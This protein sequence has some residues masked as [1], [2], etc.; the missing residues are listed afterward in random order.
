MICKRNKRNED[1]ARKFKKKK[2]QNVTARR[3]LP[4]DKATYGGRTAV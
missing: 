4:L 1:K 3:E 2:N